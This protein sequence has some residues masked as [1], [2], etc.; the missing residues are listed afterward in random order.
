[1]EIE[2]KR[3][4]DFPRGTLATLLKDGYVFLNRNLN[5]IGM[6]NGKSLMIFFMIIPILLILA[7]L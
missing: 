4:T 5:V 1:M 2:F 3:I 7:A 6:T